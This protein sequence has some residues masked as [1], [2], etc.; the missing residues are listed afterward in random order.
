MNTLRVGVVRGGVSDEYTVSLKT[1]GAFLRNL[2]EYCEGVDILIDKKG[3]WHCGGIPQKMEDIFAHVD[4]ALNA[5]HGCYG[6]D[7][8]IQ[9]CFE[10]FGIP[11]TG[12]GSFGS[13]LAMNKVIAKERFKAVGLKT[14]YAVNLSKDEYGEGAVVRLYREFPQPSV[15][16]PHNRGSSFG[17][18][19]AHSFDEFQKAID[20]AFLHSD[21]VLIEEYKKGR[22]VSCG[23]LD[24]FR[25][26]E[27]Y[28]F[29]PIE[30]IP[31]PHSAFFDYDAKYT[32]ISQELCPSPN[33][34][35]EEKDEIM[36]M[37]ISAHKALG[38]RHYSRS[39][40]ILTP[41]GIYLLEINTLPGLTEESLLPK[42]SEAVGLSFS[43]FVEHLIKLALKNNKK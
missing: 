39:D 22:E 9:Q 32:G 4:V 18:V 36:T 7:G 26:Q 25:E 34:S 41:Q 35:L 15:V 43:G 31:P 27:H 23:V 6:E 33:L 2:P 28:A 12:S 24:D 13:A 1:G 40:F 8:K 11:Y 5:L 42:A 38:L 14:P 17:V 37:A 16:K 20:E 30:I 3:L 29:P 19:I 10:S 21:V